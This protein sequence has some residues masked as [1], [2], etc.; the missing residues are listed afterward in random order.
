MA[1]QLD[2]VT[3]AFSFSGRAIA[4]LL[5]AQGH[6][7]RTLTGHRLRES[8]FGDQV[9]AYMFN[10]DNPDLLAQT[11]HGAT[12]LYNT[13]WVRLPKRRVS[14]KS[15]L[16]N[17]RTLVSAAKEAGVQRIVHFSVA[18]A[19]PDSRLPY[20][21]GKG[22]VEQIILGSGIPCTIIRPTLVFGEGDILVN[23]IA[24]MLRRIPLFMLAGS[25]EY[26]VQPIQVDDLAKLA[27]MVRNSAG[28]EIVD[29]AGPETLTFEELVRLTARAVGSRARIIHVPPPIALATGWLLGLALRDV[30]LTRHELAG[31]SAGLLTAQAHPLATTRFTDWVLDNCTNLGRRYSSEM[32]R[33]YA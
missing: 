14:F 1:S 13:Y 10:F 15:A 32:R 24:W 20:F 17:T 2:I 33:H 3:G 12:T 27:V 7:V 25:G 29:G 18:N 19:D 4:R 5:L 11:L 28:S 16:E 23:N 26:P 9:P 31:L 8:P 30:V 6:S 21:R 22:A